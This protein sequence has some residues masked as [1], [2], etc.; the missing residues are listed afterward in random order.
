[1]ADPVNLLVF[2]NT[3]ERIATDGLS[4]RLCESLEQ[5]KPGRSD[6]ILEAL[7]RAGELECGLKDC[8]WP[9]VSRACTLTDVLAGSYLSCTPSTELQLLL[10]EFC[11]LPFPEVIEVSPP[12]GLA[13]YALHPRDFADEASRS[14]SNY[15]YAVIGIRSIGTV[16]SA[17]WTAALRGR[18]IAASRITVRPSGHPYNRVTV[19]N[20]GQISWIHQ[21]QRIGSRFIVVD[22][23]PGLSGSSFLSVGESLVRHGVDAERITFWGTRA[24]EANTL[25]SPGAATRSRQ[26]RWKCIAPNFYTR[27]DHG[28]F[29]GNGEW[30]ALLLSGSDKWPACWPQIERL[31]FVS[32]DGTEIL[33]FEGFGRFGAQARKRAD[34]ISELGF[35]PS[36]RDASN[37][38]SAYAFV[39]GRPMNRPEICPSLIEQIARYCAYRRSEFRH[40]SSAP[41]E[42]LEMVRFNT[43]QELGIDLELPSDIFCSTNSVICDGRMQPHEWIASTGENVLKVD[44]CSHGDDHFFPGPTDIAWDL[45]GAMVE[46]DMHEDASN[47]LLSCYAR[48]SGDAAKSRIGS[49]LMAY[50]AFRMAYCK[51][52]FTATQGADEE[53]RLRRA[54]DFYRGRLL[55]DLRRA[56][57]VFKI[58]Q[59]DDAKLCRSSA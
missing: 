37:G 41:D 14:D 58:H 31:K 20:V 10:R 51:M 36:V 44:A 57:Y 59:S 18:G 8:N 29:V 50:G 32:S 6:E 4:R 27:L 2:R 15:S 33:K 45:A 13:Y 9:D 30:R 49:Y 43:S 55:R 56:G 24:S 42:L 12:E 19:F 48:H 25:C 40:G 23:G 22:E 38:L 16:L 26:F 52:A 7:V 35:G 46:W 21:Q 53:G 54:Y 3:R 39:S 17:L 11:E 47:L 28:R 1:M 34:R 5:I